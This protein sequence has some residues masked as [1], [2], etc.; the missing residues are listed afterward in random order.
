[1]IAQGRSD[2][3]MGTVLIG[4]ILNVVLDPIFIFIFK[5]GV[6]GAAWATILSQ[7]FSAI[8]ALY[9]LRKTNLPVR[10]VWEKFR[11]DLCKKVL[12]LGFAPFLTYAL[13]ST[14]LII[15]NA[16]LQR[17]GG[18]GEGDILVMSTAI[19]QSYMLLITSPLGGITLG[20]QGVVSYNLGAGDYKRVKKA[21]WC[22]YFVC[23]SFCTVILCVTMF[24][25]P[26]FVRLFTPDQELVSRSV[27]YIKIY[28]AGVLGM[29]AQWTVTDMGTALGQRRM[30]L[31]CSLVR[32]GIY[33]AGVLLLPILFTPAAAFAAQP[34]CDIVGSMISIFIFFRVLPRILATQKKERSCL[35]QSSKPSRASQRS[36]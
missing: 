16:T 35:T 15:L 27:T 29:A 24:A 14:L 10:L 31:F 5:M 8:F 30:T 11:P 7:A 23:L 32:K 36:R 13:D 1:M 18:H 34:L 33:V 21:L 25:S 6:A 19:I 2:L 28:A 17:T 22:V 20:C 3:G 26:Y 12:S 9:C 4:T